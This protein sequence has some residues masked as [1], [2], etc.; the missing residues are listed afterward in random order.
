M[1]FEHYFYQILKDT[2]M[3]DEFFIDDK[4]ESAF[5]ISCTQIKPDKWQLVGHSL[6][7]IATYPSHKKAL[8]ALIKVVENANIPVK[9]YRTTKHRKTKVLFAENKVTRIEPDGI[10]PLRAFNLQLDNQKQIKEDK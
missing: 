4:K 9:I 6:G 1:A 2:F 7:V 10:N 3:E 8:T 5:I